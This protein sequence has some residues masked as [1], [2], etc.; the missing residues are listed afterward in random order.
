MELGISL[1]PPGLLFALSVFRYLN[2][3][4]VLL[5]IPLSKTLGSFSFPDTP[6]DTLGQRKAHCRPPIAIPNDRRESPTVLHCARSLGEL[7]SPSKGKSFL[8]LKT[9][10]GESACTMLWLE[11]NGFQRREIINCACIL[12]YSYL[13]DDCEFQVLYAWLYQFNCLGLLDQPSS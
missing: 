6:I 12:K 10:L 8:C 13:K 9:M 3:Q 11:R 7:T 1:R 5:N 2:N 4:P